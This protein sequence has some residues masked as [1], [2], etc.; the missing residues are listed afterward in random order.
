MRL[1]DAEWDALTWALHLEKCLDGAACGTGGS[2]K[3]A[4]MRKLET[5]GLVKETWAVKVDGDGYTVEPER[6]AL[7][8]ALTDPG[9]LVATSLR[10]IE[11]ALVD[12]MSSSLKGSAGA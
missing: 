7:C 9:R 1:T 8:Y 11:G 3:K 12:G 6:E 2:L 10:A 5:R 4:T